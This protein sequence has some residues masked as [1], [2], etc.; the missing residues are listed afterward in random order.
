MPHSFCRFGCIMVIV[1]GAA[2]V[3]VSRAEDSSGDS[4]KPAR[5]RKFEFAYAA[6]VT[7]LPPGKVARVWLPVPPT[8]EEQQ[9]KMVAKD[10]PEKHKISREP[11]YGNDI[12][13]VEA[14]AGEDGAVFLSVTYRV[15]RREVKADLK[16]HDDT[17]AEFARFLA[18]DAKVPIGGKPLELIKDKKIPEDQLAMGE[19]FYEVVNNHMRYSKEG[20]GWGRGDAVWACDSKYGNCTDFHSLFI[21]LAR[22]HKIP[23]KF[24]MGFPIPEKRGEG[25]VAGYHCWAKFRPQ[26]KGWVPVDISEANKNPKMKDYYFGNL[27]EDRV[28]FTTGRDLTLVPKQTGEPLNFFVYPYV[29]VDGKAYPA[30]KVKRKFTYKDVR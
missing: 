29:E 11:K 9:V 25:E 19:L 23:A 20:T 8:N 6:T 3:P 22:S 18:P 13:Y 24:E 7:G 17:A 26:G 27:T 14:R 5:S 4:K 12:L 28:T 16:E 30:E 10:L 1:V 15:L 2:L 21:S